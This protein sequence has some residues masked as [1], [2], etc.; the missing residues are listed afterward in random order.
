MIL[1]PLREVNEKSY[2]NTFENAIVVE[3]IK[4][5]I[6]EESRQW[7]VEPLEA[8]II[9]HVLQERRHC[10]IDDCRFEG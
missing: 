8:F 7:L 2:L 1:L 4:V 3:V 6:S 10:G 5:T 9:L